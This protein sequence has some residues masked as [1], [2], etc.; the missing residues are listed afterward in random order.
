MT[1]REQAFRNWDREQREAERRRDAEAL[2]QYQRDC[3]ASWA[4][5]GAAK[6]AA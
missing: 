2:A 4:A 3:I 5:R 1:D 6:G